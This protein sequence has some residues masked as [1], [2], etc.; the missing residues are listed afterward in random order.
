M[1]DQALEDLLAD[2]VRDVRAAAAAALGD[3]RRRRSNAARLL[4]IVHDDCAEVAEIAAATLAA[5][6]PGLVSRAWAPTRTRI[7][8]LRHAASMLQAG[9]A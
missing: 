3:G 2:D 6:A 5:I 4:E 1:S 9:L 8:S 7:R